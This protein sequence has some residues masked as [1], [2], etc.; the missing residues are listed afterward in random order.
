[1]RSIAAQTDDD[2]NAIV[3]AN[4]GSQLPD[5]PHGFEV[6]WVDFPPNPLHERGRASREAFREAFRIDKGRRVLAGMF[7]GGQMKHVMIVDDDDFVS[8]RLVAF[9]TARPRAHGWYIKS[10]YVWQEGDPFLYRRT[11]FW[12]VCGT[13]HVV[14]ADLYGLPETFETADETYI[15]RML[16]SHKYLRGHLASA[17]TPLA[18][19]PF[20]GAVYRVGNIGSHSQRRGVLAEYFSKRFLVKR[21]FE[22]VRRLGN[23]RPLSPRLRREFSL[24]R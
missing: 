23:L 8:R 10:G 1:M 16:G 22:F 9:V 6:E 24:P 13:S 2:W 7:R 11:D 19:L 14:R 20:E 15:R 18:P 17:G 12:Q 21:P 4:R 3:V 5:L